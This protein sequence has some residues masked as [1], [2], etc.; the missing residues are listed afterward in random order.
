LK[1]MLL[2]NNILVLFFFLSTSLSAEVPPLPY[3]DHL[4]AQFHKLVAWN[5]YCDEQNRT[6]D[7]IY[8]FVYEPGKNLVFSPNNETTD[9]F[10]YYLLPNSGVGLFDIE[11]SQYLNEQ[12]R[13]FNEG[14]EESTT[15]QDV[16]VYA[17][18]INDF[19]GYLKADPNELV[20]NTEGSVL[21]YLKKNPSQFGPEAY[22]SYQSYQTALQER[23]R[24]FQLGHAENQLLIYGSGFKAYEWKQQYQRIYTLNASSSGLLLEETA[25]C[26]KAY[27]VEQA[28]QRNYPFHFPTQSKASRQFTNAVLSQLEFLSKPSLRESCEDCGPQL[29]SYIQQ[30]WDETAKQ[31]LLDRCQQLRDFPDRM[32]HA[33]SIARFIQSL[34]IVYDD[35][36]D[37]ATAPEEY[38]WSGQ[39]EEYLLFEAALQAQS[40]RV[41]TAH[42][43]LKT[44]IADEDW[45]Q[46]FISLY[47]FDGPSF[48]KT[49]SVQDRVEALQVLAKGPMLGRWL[50]GNHEEQVIHLLD[51]VPDEPL[52]IEQFL[53]ALKATPGLLELLFNKIQNHWVGEAARLQFIQSLS[54]LVQQ[55]PAMNQL[56]SGRTLIWDLPD[57]VIKDAFEYDYQF[58]SDAWL[59]FELKQCTAVDHGYTF[60]NFSDHPPSFCTEK[61]NISWEA[62]DP[63]SLIDIVVIDKI[64]VIN[65]CGEQGCQGQV[66]KN[67]PAILAAYLI[68]QTA[69]DENIQQILLGI[70]I[71]GLAIGMGELA[72]AAQ[73]GS[74]IRLLIAGYVLASDITSISLSSEAFK[75]YLIAE[76]GEPE[77]LKLYEHFQFF[78]TL[79]SILAGTV[80]IVALDE[81]AKAVASIEKMKRVGISI[82]DIE[83]QL[84]GPISNLSGQELKNLAASMQQELEGTVEGRNA[85]RAAKSALGID[86]LASLIINLKNAGASEELIDRII[87]LPVNDGKLL[88]SQLSRQENRLISDFNRKLALVDG[89]ESYRKSADWPAI[90]NWSESLFYSHFFD[91][92][93]GS[94][95]LE[96]FTAFPRFAKSYALLYGDG[97]TSFS[98]FRRSLDDIKTI[99]EY[100]RAYPNQAAELKANYLAAA[101]KREF[102]DGLLGPGQAGE[103][104][105]HRVKGLMEAIDVD[106]QP[107]GVTL[108]D[109]RDSDT[110]N[111]SWVKP[112]SGGKAGTY[113]RY[114]EPDTKTLVLYMGFQYDAPSWIKDVSI[115]LVEGKGI[116]TSAYMTLRTMKKL[117]IPNGILKRVKLDLVVNAE[118]MKDYYL[119]MQEQ[120]FTQLNQIGR[121]LLDKPGIQYAVTMIRQAGY[122]ID[123]V[124][125]LEKDFSRYSTTH[126][127]RHNDHIEEIT[128]EWLQKHGLSWE[129]KLYYMTEIYLELSPI[130]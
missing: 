15:G 113:Q 4:E 107:A 40:T 92:S 51:Y 116:P 114:W 84:G 36:A 21:N 81:A 32:A 89:W 98:A 115:P 30:L 43:S 45:Y 37:T 16:A 29:S 128:E 19:K 9:W 25:T 100:L 52:Y 76:L 14:G 93:I 104:V 124:K 75:S 73:L 120:G 111:S 66:F 80:G 122:H 28:K 41:S 38:N 54:R 50:I 108:S 72:L 88:L 130:P 74:K 12:L 117:G 59:Q 110:M 7:K 79:N 49:L 31:F 71:A 109:F 63:F 61:E 87:L 78:T 23:V 57:Q 53:G 27:Q 69:V 56:Q 127:I 94:S 5:E 90:E 82:A 126:Y 95:F 118:I 60:N 17:F 91:L 48:F 24:G 112:N 34:G 65:T 119:I 58:N 13:A 10:N 101:N 125:V 121:H 67:V 39:W 103:R 83:A 1:T 99:D 97:S 86:E 123:D 35:Y 42:Q 8:F 3:G 46:V 62:I 33:F 47:H 70:D 106:Y 18:F 68:K 6:S 44:A 64:T 105:V 2:K 26:R 20:N 102:I 22:E 55:R 77:G 129:T 11:S 96:A 85:L